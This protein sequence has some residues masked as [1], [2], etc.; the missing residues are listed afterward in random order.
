MNIRAIRAKN[1]SV[2]DEFFLDYSA[3]SPFDKD[4][5]YKKSSFCE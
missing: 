3:L 5:L 1:L 4:Y 2:W